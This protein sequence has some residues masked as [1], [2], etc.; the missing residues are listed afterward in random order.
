MGKQYNF[1]KTFSY[2]GK[3]YYIPNARKN[4]VFPMVAAG[5]ATVGATL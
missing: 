1:V 3:R 2:D 5:V 4:P